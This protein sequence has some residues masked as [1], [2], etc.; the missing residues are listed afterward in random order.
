MGLMAKAASLQKNSTKAPPT[1]KKQ[2]KDS[3]RPKQVT[4]QPK[5]AIPRPKQARRKPALLAKKENLEFGGMVTKICNDALQVKKTRQLYEFIVQ[6]MIEFTG[7]EQIVILGRVAQP[8]DGRNSSAKNTVS[9][10]SLEIFKIIDVLGIGR[11]EIPENIHWAKVDQLKGEVISIADLKHKIR[12]QKES[13]ALQTLLTKIHAQ[14]LVPVILTERIQNLVVLGRQTKGQQFSGSYQ[15]VHQ[16]LMQLI[17]TLGSIIMSKIDNVNLLRKQIASHT[18]KE[19]AQDHTIKILSQLE[20]NPKINDIVYFFRELLENEYESR[21]FSLIAYNNLEDSYRMLDQIGLSDSAKERFYLANQTELIKIVK[22]RH[23]IIE[24]KNFAKND[25]L[26]YCY[27]PQDLEKMSHCI[28]V[29]FYQQNQLVFLLII[30]SISKTWDRYKVD[31]LT[32]FA[33]ISSYTIATLLR[34]QEII[35]DSHDSYTPLEKRINYEF[36]KYLAK[37]SCL[38]LI[39][40][41]IQNLRM[42]QKNIEISRQDEYFR[43]VLILFQEL[44][45]GKQ[46]YYR[47]SKYHFILVLPQIKG[48]QVRALEK[49]INK[50]LPRTIDQEEIKIVYQIASISAP[51]EANNF[52]KFIAILD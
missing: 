12:E 33:K 32:A 10:K 20:N 39:D 45:I 16:N 34:R 13:K 35:S 52:E 18:K 50:Q 25:D 6:A 17:G 47:I 30:H 2:V 48:R 27:S 14:Y 11:Q 5:R 44:L 36:N 42:I 26:Q 46:Y 37:K 31:A 3:P 41:R 40:I 51:T 23:S 15:E 38:S 8:D 24:I 7:C 1:P 21:S 19:I 43:K 29:P 4:S 49:K 9:N 28:L 22:N